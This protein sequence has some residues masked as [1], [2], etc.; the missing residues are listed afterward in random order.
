MKL[1]Y[2]LIG[3]FF[4]LLPG[5]LSLQAQMPTQARYWNSARGYAPFIHSTPDCVL[6][7]NQ[8]ATPLADTLT[9]DNPYRDFTLSFLADQIHSHPSKAYPYFDSNNKERHLKNPSWGFFVSDSRHKTI[10]FT[11]T[12]E[13]VSDPFSSHRMLRL[14]IRPDSMTSASPLSLLI[15]NADP[16]GANLWRLKATASGV[17]L[18]GGHKEM[19]KLVEIPIILGDCQ[20]FGFTAYPGARLSVKD[21][22]IATERPSGSQTI[23]RWSSRDLLDEHLKTSEDL[24]E[25]YWKIF[26]MTLD[27][28]LLKLGGDYLFAIVKENGSYSIIYLDGARINPADWI[29]GMLKGL[30]IPDA[31]PGVYSVHWIDSEGASLTKGIKAQPGPDNTLVIQFPYQAST[32]RLRRL[33]A[34]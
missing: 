17:T 34:K 6:I 20:K 1:K 33:P 22:A 14:D 13:E 15:E 2:S 23:T 4:T 10:S 29:P 24:L 9:L 25:G 27:E 28:S 18:A 12:P 3:A 7:D 31:F 19:E 21:I 30:L 26:D 32:I 11:I 8:S 5:F 16:A